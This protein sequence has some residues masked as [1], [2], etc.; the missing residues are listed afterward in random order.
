M[1]A[2]RRELIYT[3]SLYLYLGPY[4]NSFA[5]WINCACAWGYLFVLW[6]W[7]SYMLRQFLQVFPFS[8]A[9][10]TCPCCWFV[11]MRVWHMLL[12]VFLISVQLLSCT[13][14][15]RFPLISYCIAILKWLP[16]RLSCSFFLIFFCIAINTWYIIVDPII[17]KE[18]IK[19]L[20][21]LPERQMILNSLLCFLIH[22]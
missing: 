6:M 15:S 1:E 19:K 17:H 3:L 9:T 7:F 16:Q 10:S 8:F 12:T 18:Y 5:A 22:I 13:F 14:F 20:Q 11:F 2:I 21:L 4:S